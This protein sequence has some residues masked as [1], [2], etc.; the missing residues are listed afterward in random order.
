VRANYLSQL[1]AN[2]FDSY[3][4]CQGSEFPYEGTGR[5]LIQYGVF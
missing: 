5:G 2:Q 1:S 4:V 3:E